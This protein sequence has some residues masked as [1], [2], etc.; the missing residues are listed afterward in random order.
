MFKVNKK[1]A[2]EW[3]QNVTPCSSVSIVNFEHLNADWEVNMV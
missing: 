3:H 1:K 2:P